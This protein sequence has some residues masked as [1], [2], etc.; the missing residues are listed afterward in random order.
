[1]VS[2]EKLNLSIDLLE[3]NKRTGAR[4]HGD[5]AL[6][7]CIRVKVP[8]SIFIYSIFSLFPLPIFTCLFVSLLFL[9]NNNLQRMLQKS[10]E[11]DVLELLKSQNFLSPNHGEGNVE[12]ASKPYYS[13]YLNPYSPNVTFLYHLKTSENRR[14]SDV[15]R[16]NRNVT[17]G[18]YG[19]NPN[20][21]HI[22]PFFLIFEGPFLKVDSVALINTS[23]C[24]KYRKFQHLFR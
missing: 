21:I 2:L 18:E 14:F 22:A 3:I 11:I 10:V 23:Y 5:Q 17:L 13:Y 4:G 16:G 8:F 19:L 24:Q 20:L 7:F 1:M 6:P 12:K 9:I 15:F